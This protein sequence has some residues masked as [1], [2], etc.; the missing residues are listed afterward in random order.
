MPT[1][2]WGYSPTKLKMGS[3]EI[4]EVRCLPQHP[5]LSA[6]LRVPPLVPDSL[7]G[8]NSLGVAG[9]SVYLANRGTDCLCSRIPF[10]GFLFREQPWETESVWPFGTQD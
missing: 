9:V 10:Q 3:R 7:S 4:Y 2:T 1:D 5:V 6:P 8:G